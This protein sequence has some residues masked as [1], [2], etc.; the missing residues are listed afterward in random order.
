MERLDE[1]KVDLLRLWGEGLVQDPREEVRAAGRAILLLINEVEHLHVD[2]WH[3]RSAIEA[4]AKR[5][6]AEVADE[7]LGFLD[8]LRAIAGR[9]SRESPTASA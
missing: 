2:L 3:A 4:E 1:E 7:E 9:P 5:P 8:A 6:V